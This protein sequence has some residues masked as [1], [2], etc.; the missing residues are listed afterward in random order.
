MLRHSSSYWS[1]WNTFLVGVINPICR[2]SIHRTFARVIRFN[3]ALW[4][5]RH[6]FW[7][8]EVTMR[9][10]VVQW[11]EWFFHLALELATRFILSW[12]YHPFITWTLSFAAV[13]LINQTNNLGLIG[14]RLNSLHICIQYYCETM[15]Q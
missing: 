1:I 10:T 6:R 2:G 11:G 13:I 12:A 8:K 4:S 14:T 3:S 7:C 15:E 9:C 5:W